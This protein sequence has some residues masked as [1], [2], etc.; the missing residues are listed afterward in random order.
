[1]VKPWD[2]SPANKAKIQRRAASDSSV[3][4]PGLGDAAWGELY[5][6]RL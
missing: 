3:L 1:M 2:M 6:V 4:V 5:W